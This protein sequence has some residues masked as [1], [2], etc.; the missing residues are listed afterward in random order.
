MLNSNPRTPKRKFFSDFFPARS[1]CDQLLNQA[2][3][4]FIFVSKKRKQCLS[5]PQENLQTSTDFDYDKA[6][7]ARSLKERTLLEC[8]KLF[9]V[10]SLS[11]DKSPCVS[12]VFIEQCDKVRQ[13]HPSA[14]A[15]KAYSHPKKDFPRNYIIQLNWD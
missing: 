4:E 2:V 6:S 14:R 9:N 5:K 10:Y 11:I 1:V 15:T 13:V 7:F 8:W 3:E 12:V